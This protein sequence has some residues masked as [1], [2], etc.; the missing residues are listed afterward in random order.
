[1]RAVVMRDGR[2]VVDDIA[3]QR[4]R[5]GQV[6]AR[7]LACGICGSDLHT[8]HHVD[9]IGAQMHEASELG[10]Q[11]PLPIAPAITD[12]GRDVVLGHEFVAEVVEVG[13]GT[14]NCA[15]GDVVVSVPVVF[16]E[17]GLYMV[18]Y[19]D[20]YPGGYG[21]Y[22]CL[23]DMLALKVPNGLDPHVAA[24]T[25]PMAVSVHAVNRSGIGPGD[26]AVVLGCGPVGL[27]VIAALRSIGVET[28]VGSDLSAGRRALAGVMG[29]TEVS[30]PVTEPALDTW[31]RVDGRKPLVIFEAVG[32]P[33]MLDLA[34]RDAPRDAQVL[35][36][37]VCMQ[38]D[39]IR[40]MG[41][42]LREITMRFV[43]AYS[44]EEFAD[45]LRRIAEGELGELS[46]MIT[47]TVGLDGVPGAF[48]ALA[49]P[50]QHAKILITP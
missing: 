47:G 18:G 39:T 7:T 9:E 37:G 36:V 2:L 17:S 25:E 11:G 45:T 31:R 32:V 42:I 15:A 1:M 23:A 14:G 3:D 48:D 4:P 50:D 43:Y 27:A 22:L 19:S 34:I 28:I 46:P 33:G 10:A 13:E 26:A 41:A 5:P 30:D 24:L 49:D 40:P 21:E 29:A 38:P 20:V 6:L 35:V 12:F 8:L 44:L 16:D